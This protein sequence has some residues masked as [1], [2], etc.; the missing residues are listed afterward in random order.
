MKTSANLPFKFAILVRRMQHY[1]DQHG[2]TWVVKGYYLFGFI[3]IYVSIW[4]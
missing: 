1:A 4:D 2:N 3:P